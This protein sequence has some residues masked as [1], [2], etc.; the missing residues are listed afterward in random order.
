MTPTQ[1][2]VYSIDCLLVVALHHWEFH[3]SRP[4]ATFENFFNI[5]KKYSYSEIL[6]QVH[7][8]LYLYIYL[9]SSLKTF[10]ASIYL[11]IIK[12]PEHWEWHHPDTF[13]FNFR[14]IF[15]MQSNINLSV[16]C[17][18]L[19]GIYSMQ[20]WTSTTRHG[21]KEAQKD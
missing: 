15:R 1:K 5:Y 6:E 8:V 2:C 9:F 21:E 10:L 4:D 16:A 13:I 14:G 19:I 3:L 17:I 7:H 18:F 20:G 11:S 12:E